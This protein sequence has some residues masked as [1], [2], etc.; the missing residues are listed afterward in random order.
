MFQP[1]RKPD[2]KK[3]FKEL[4]DNA[5]LFGVLVCGCRLLPYIFHFLS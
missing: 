4:Q 3:A 5:V 2:S 1:P